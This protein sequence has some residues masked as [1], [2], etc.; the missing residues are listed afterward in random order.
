MF[1]FQKFNR[2]YEFVSKIK[3]EELTKLKE[4]IK[5]ETNPRQIEK[6]T[7]LIQRMVNFKKTS[8]ES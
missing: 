6:M 8:G 2:N 7:Y 5:E 3:E 4:D 1:S